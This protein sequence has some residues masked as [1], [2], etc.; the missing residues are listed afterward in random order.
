MNNFPTH[1]RKRAFTLIE[2]LVVISIIALLIG[3]LLPA[4]GKARETARG[5]Q[6]LSN[7]RQLGVSSTAYEVEHKE[8]VVTGTVPRPLGFTTWYDPNTFGGKTSSPG[9]AGLTL[10]GPIEDRPLNPYVLGYDPKPDPSPTNRQ[11]AEPFLCPADANIQNGPYNQL[12]GPG[13]DDDPNYSAYE[14][15]GTSYAEASAYAFEDPRID[16]SSL[17]SLLESKS[18]TW[19]ANGGG[20]SDTLLFAEFNFVDSYQFLGG[21]PQEGMH[22]Q[23]AQHNAVF[24]DGSAGTVNTPS[25]SLQTGSVSHPQGFNVFPLRGSD[26][27]SLYPTPR[28]F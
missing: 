4:L 3:I 27:W 10:Y 6:C 28:K 24:Y 26:E 12:W 19:L 1:A 7:L 13:F 9:F 14:L 11:E 21:N 2:L 8:Q 5:M 16:F 25:D 17:D 18:R 20:Q 15:Q 23:F 22:G